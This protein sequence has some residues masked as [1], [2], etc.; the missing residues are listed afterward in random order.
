M[1]NNVKYW[2]KAVPL[3]TQI[4]CKTVC[5]QNLRTFCKTNIAPCALTH[6]KI[7]EREKD[8]Y[9]I[10]CIIWLSFHEKFN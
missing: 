6:K 2:P 5:V 10:Y 8:V 9:C 1:L 4:F 7:G 3:S